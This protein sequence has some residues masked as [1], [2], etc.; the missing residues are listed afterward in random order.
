MNRPGY[1]VIWTFGKPPLPLAPA[2]STWFINDPNLFYQFKETSQFLEMRQNVSNKNRGI[3]TPRVRSRPPGWTGGRRDRTHEKV[4]V[5]K[6]KNSVSKKV[7]CGRGSIKKR[8][9]W[10]EAGKLLI[11]QNSNIWGSGSF[12]LKKNG[13]CLGRPT[14]LI[15][16]HCVPLSHVQ[17]SS[18]GLNFPILLLF[19]KCCEGQHDTKM[20]YT[21][22]I[23]H[24]NCTSKMIRLIKTG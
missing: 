19:S 23:F 9:N 11:F 3:C 13:L 16:Y 18:K 20:R 1:V 6:L 5:R 17:R 8:G 12:G 4:I 7:G 21:G 2:M 10:K 24:Q 14:S 15:T 22:S